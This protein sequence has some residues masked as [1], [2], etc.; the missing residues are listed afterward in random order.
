MVMVMVMV[1]PVVVLPC[2]S[3]AQRARARARARAVS[4]L[5]YPICAP[6]HSP[7]LVSRDPLAYIYRPY[8][9]SPDDDRMNELW[10]RDRVYIH[11]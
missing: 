9:P 1:Y 5:I 2:T 11:M 6:H 8:R 4:V 3:L 7:P 10:S